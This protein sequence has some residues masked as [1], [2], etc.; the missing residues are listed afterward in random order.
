MFHFITFDLGQVCQILSKFNLTH[1]SGDGRENTKFFRLC[2]SFLPVTAQFCSYDC[3]G[4]MTAGVTQLQTE[5]IVYGGIVKK[6]QSN[7]QEPVITR[8]SPDVGRSKQ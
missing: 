6:M 2:S 4:I 8:Q 7:L 1:A 3:F 5:S